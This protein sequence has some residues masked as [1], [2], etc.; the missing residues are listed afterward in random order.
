MSP[1]PEAAEAAKQKPEAKKATPP[2]S[3][4]LPEA[5][6]Q[7]DATMRMACA[8]SPRL[9]LHMRQ[10]L[11]AEAARVPSAQREQER[12]GQ[13]M[14]AITVSDPQNDQMWLGVE[15][16]GSLKEGAYNLNLALRKSR[17]QHEGNTEVVYNELVTLGKSVKNDPEKFYKLI[18]SLNE[19][20]YGK[21]TMSASDRQQLPNQTSV[22]SQ[23]MSEEMKGNFTCADISLFMV[24]YLDSVGVD[25]IS[26]MGMATTSPDKAA[27]YGGDTGHAITVVDLGNGKY[28]VVG[29]EQNV[30]LPARSLEEAYRLLSKRSDAITTKGT[31]LM[32]GA[33]NGEYY[34]KYILDQE[35]LYGSEVEFSSDENLR[36][37]TSFVNDLE[38]MSAMEKQDL[39]KALEQAGK[40]GF[41]LSS[42][43]IFGSTGLESGETDS[44]SRIRFEGLTGGGRYVTL[45]FNLK[46]A[47]SQERFGAVMTSVT[48]TSV[49]RVAAEVGTRN[50][51]NTSLFDSARSA[52]GRLAYEG[53]HKV[54]DADAIGVNAAV[55]YEHLEGEA[56]TFEGHKNTTIDS[57]SFRADGRYIRTFNLAENTALDLWAGTGV[58][59]YMLESSATGNRGSE[60]YV[61]GAQDYDFRMSQ[62]LGTTFRRTGDMVDYSGSVAFSVVEDTQVADPSVQNIGLTAG[63]MMQGEMT[64]VFRPVDGLGVYGKVEAVRLQMPVNTRLLAGYKIGVT[65]ND[66]AGAEG[67]N[68]SA[69]WAQQTSTDDLHMSYM[70]A[71]LSDLQ[72]QVLGTRIS[73][74]DENSGSTVGVGASYA[75]TKDSL[76]GDEA[77][78]TQ[79]AVDYSL[80]F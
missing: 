29:L 48:D 8:R 78:D 24:R 3:T 11:E 37:N 80:A 6:R 52:G 49:H 60:A 7:Q 73:Y 67:L 68:I 15:E 18:V 34:R 72:T 75:R 64:L 28:G 44:G 63:T 71:D 16:D 70:T 51:Q 65:L 79:F 12:T 43:S 50:T 46:I 59:G 42:I 57:L 54:G 55:R 23:V 32:Y 20:L 77:R 2:A 45:D 61:G 66:F 39:I 36:M 38:A 1:G 17:E 14:Q 5:V 21:Y 13:I 74:F 56:A 22:L 69:D 47:R 62:T 9:G 27:G 33:K 35:T 31:M 30:V 26:F 25:A 10:C 4:T 58:M 41:R 19:M 40:N 53:T 76:T